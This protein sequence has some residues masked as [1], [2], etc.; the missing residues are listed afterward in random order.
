MINQIAI[1]LCDSSLGCQL[2]SIQVANQRRVSRK[3]E[4]RTY[5]TGQESKFKKYERVHFMA[6]RRNDGTARPA[7]PHSYHLRALPFHPL[8][9]SNLSRKASTTSAR[10]CHSRPDLLDPNAHP[11]SPFFQSIDSPTCLQHLI[12]P[13]RPRYFLPRSSNGPW[14]SRRCRCFHIRVVDHMEEAAR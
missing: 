3:T 4:I 12:C 10:I 5:C 9:S 7:H 14:R 6:A 13:R 8:P 11:A 1:R 2:T